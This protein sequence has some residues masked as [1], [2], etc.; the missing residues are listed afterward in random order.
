MSKTPY[1]ILFYQDALADPY[2]QGW[3]FDDMEFESA[4][5]AFDAAH[6]KYRETAFRIVKLCY[7]KEE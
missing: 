3:D 7:P 4:E 1:R 5:A 6:E 2:H